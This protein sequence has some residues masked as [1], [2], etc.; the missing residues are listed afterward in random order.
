MIKINNLNKVF[1]DNEVLKDINLEINQ[2]E[3][4]AII[5]PSGSGKS[6]LLRC[7]NLLEVPT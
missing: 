1:G 3:V 6:T 7:M 2:G 5:G 4:V